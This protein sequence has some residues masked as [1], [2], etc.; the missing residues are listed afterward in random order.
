VALL[1]ADPELVLAFPRTK[2]VDDEGNLIRDFDDHHHLMQDLPSLRFRRVMDTTSLC[3][4]HLGVLRRS[5]MLK[6]R[7]IGGELASDI[8]FVAEMSLY[9][10]FYVI[11]EY[12]FFRRFHEKASSWEREDME[13][14][15]AYYAPGSNGS[16][17]MHT[18]RRFA[19]LTAAVMRAPIAARERVR[20]LRYLAEKF[21]RKR[22]VLWQEVK[23]LGHIR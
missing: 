9:G 19:G 17:G 20:L 12:L 23:A 15:R 21:A 8:R 1:D 5:V 6:T 13:R 18:W 2:V 14:Q 22:S 4:A 3:H 10:K 16:F 7:L 11:P